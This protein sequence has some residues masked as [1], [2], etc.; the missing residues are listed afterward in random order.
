MNLIDFK[1][2]NII[3]NNN[4]FNTS[5][6]IIIIFILI[7]LFLYNWSENPEFDTY[8]DLLQKR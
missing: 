2:K 1:I 8:F 6:K 7:I 3:E 5:K 4:P